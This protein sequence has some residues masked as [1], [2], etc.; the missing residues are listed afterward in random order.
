MFKTFSYYN[1]IIVGLFV[2]NSSKYSQLTISPQI[3][4]L[5]LFKIQISLILC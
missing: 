3:K 5:S 2:L 4:F 1:M